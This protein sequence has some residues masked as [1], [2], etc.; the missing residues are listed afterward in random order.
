VPVK[1]LML[2]EQEVNGASTEDLQY[3]SVYM[4]TQDENNMCGMSVTEIQVHKVNDDIALT[5]CNVAPFGQGDEIK[6]DCYNGKVYLNNKLYND[7][8][9]G[10]QFIELVTGNN[11]LKVTSDSTNFPPLATVLF[12][13]RYL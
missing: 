5:G 1:K 2:K 4:G 11:V 3:I 8:D 12:N 6:I 13:E 10:S 7:I 9:M